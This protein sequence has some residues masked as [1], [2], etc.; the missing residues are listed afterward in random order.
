MQPNQ[1]P[2]SMPEPVVPVFIPA[3]VDLLARAEGEKGSPLTREEVLTIR[4]KGVCMMMR[5]SHA[6]KMVQ[7]RG[8]PDI[9]PALCWEQWLD[10]R[11]RFLHR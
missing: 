3:L 1:Q 7:S 11:E 5:Q 8:Y 4:G 9:D 2:T 6:E 10:A